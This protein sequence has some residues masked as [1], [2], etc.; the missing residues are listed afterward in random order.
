LE[1]EMLKTAVTCIAIAPLAFA[2]ALATSDMASA[3]KAKKVAAKPTYEEA[4]GICTKEMDRNHIL[5]A[6]ATQRYA[7]G[8]ACMHRHGYSI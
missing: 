5:R 7:A 1:D 6:D 8:A 4:W 2:L 3:K